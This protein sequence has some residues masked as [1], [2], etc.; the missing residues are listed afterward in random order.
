M[1][2]VKSAAELKITKC[3]SKYL[4]YILEHVYRGSSEK[5]LFRRKLYIMNLYICKEAKRKWIFQSMVV[6]LHFSQDG[7][8][9]ARIHDGSISADLLESV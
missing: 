9:T 5:P 6:G 3:S 7:F 1:R 2:S 8:S 4:K